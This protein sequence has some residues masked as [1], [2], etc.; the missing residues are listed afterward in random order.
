LAPV[1]ALSAVVPAAAAVPALVRAGRADRYLADLN[2]ITRALVPAL[3]FCARHFQRQ[4]G[5]HFAGMPD[6]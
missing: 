6:G 2:P 3:F 5:F 1:R 4:T